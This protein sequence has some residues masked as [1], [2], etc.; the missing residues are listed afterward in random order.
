MSLVSIPNAFG[1]S[2]ENSLLVY[3]G[4]T[5]LD[6]SNLHATKVYLG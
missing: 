1:L 2:E 4:Q 5:Q 3:T 6:Q